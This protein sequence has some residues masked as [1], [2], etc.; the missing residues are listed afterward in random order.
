M[1]HTTRPRSHPMCL[2]TDKFSSFGS[3]FPKNTHRRDVNYLRGR[4]PVFCPG[5]E[6]RH[7]SHQ[8]VRQDCAKIFEPRKAT[9]TVRVQRTLR[10]HLSPSCRNE[11]NTNRQERIRG[12][13]LKAIKAWGQE[14]Y[15]PP[16]TKLDKTARIMIDYN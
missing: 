14:G 2:S 16:P 13:V 4:I 1:L 5:A 7:T 12:G 15:T 9:C 6:Q 8:I 10:H 11:R 3:R